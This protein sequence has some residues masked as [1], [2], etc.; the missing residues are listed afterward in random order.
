MSIENAIQNTSLNERAKGAFKRA[1]RWL[2]TPN[3]NLKGKAPEEFA[4]T[5]SGFELVKELPK[6]GPME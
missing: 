2:E 5:P 1:R 4:K 3:R 6:T